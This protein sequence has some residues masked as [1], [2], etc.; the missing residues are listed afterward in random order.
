MGFSHRD[1]R[2]ERTVREAFWAVLALVAAVS[3]LTFVAGSPL[4]GLATLIGLALVGGG[5]LVGA[6]RILGEYAGDLR[7]AQDLDLHGWLQVEAGHAVEFER[8]VGLPTQRSP[9]TRPPS[10]RTQPA[11]PAPGP[12]N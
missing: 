7:Q 6:D 1:L 9:H 5:Y 11:P 2:A 12:G 4:L 10:G 8:P 3:I